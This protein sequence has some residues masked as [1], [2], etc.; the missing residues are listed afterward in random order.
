MTVSLTITDEARRA[1]ERYADAAVE[2]EL[3][4]DASPRLLE[5]AR[6]YAAEFTRAVL[7]ANPDTFSFCERTAN[8]RARKA[9]R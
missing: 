8:A 7:A 2:L 5:E 3:A 4:G 9:G 1:A 6:S